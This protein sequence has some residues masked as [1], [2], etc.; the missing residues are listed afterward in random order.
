MGRQYSPPGLTSLSCQL[1]R[2]LGP[3]REVGQS[4]GVAGQRPTKI[5][6]NKFAALWAFVNRTFWCADSH[7]NLLA[8]PDG[9]DVCGASVNSDKRCS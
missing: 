9:A 3:G 2:I 6:S 5:S 1:M 8:G 4:G 7:R